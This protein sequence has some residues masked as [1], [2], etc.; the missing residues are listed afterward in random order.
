MN[1]QFPVRC[2]FLQGVSAN[3]LFFLYLATLFINKYKKE[4]YEDQ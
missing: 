4:I 1:P 3:V 2:L